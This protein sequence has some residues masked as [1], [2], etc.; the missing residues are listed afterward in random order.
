MFFTF[1]LPTKAIPP[2]PQTT[3]LERTLYIPIYACIIFPNVHRS[4]GRQ[5]MTKHSQNFK[6]AIRRQALHHTIQMQDQPAKCGQGLTWAT[7]IV[8]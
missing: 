7:F 5:S 1:S 6:V 4:S 3:F 8:A 2:T